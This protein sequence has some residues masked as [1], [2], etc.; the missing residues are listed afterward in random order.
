VIALTLLLAMIVLAAVI[1]LFRALSLT[2]R[3]LR[4]AIRLHTNR[5]ELVMPPGAGSAR[6]AAE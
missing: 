2:R 1:S 3:S 5:T 4:Q 6:D